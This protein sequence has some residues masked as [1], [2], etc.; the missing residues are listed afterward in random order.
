[1]AEVCHHYFS[2]PM[3]QL[4][5]ASCNA[6]L[7]AKEQVLVA[8]DNALKVSVCISAGGNDDA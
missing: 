4:G 7:T 5:D 8:L 2:F 6:N 1:M 3:T